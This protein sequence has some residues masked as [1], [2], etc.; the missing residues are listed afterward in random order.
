MGTSSSLTGLATTYM[1]NGNLIATIANS[2]GYTETM[3][4]ESNCDLLAT[5]N[6]QFSAVGK[7]AFAYG[8][9]TLGRRTSDVETG[10]TN[11][12]RPDPFG[13]PPFGLPPPSGFP[14]PDPFE[15]PPS[16]RSPARPSRAKRPCR[17]KVRSMLL[18][19]SISC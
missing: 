19:F 6:G 10:G 9:D 15:S 13:L 1:V 11:K 18:L 17:F 5:I 2:S 3:T 4:R 16:A 12:T 8:H 14:W 7:A